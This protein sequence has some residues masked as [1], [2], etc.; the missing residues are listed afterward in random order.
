[1]PVP[2]LNRPATL[3]L[4]AMALAITLSP[5]TSLAAQIRASERAQISQTIDG[6]TLKLDYSRPR[7]RTRGVE[8]IFGAEVHWGEV[9]TPG[10]NAGTKLNVDR[11]VT[12]NGVAVPA[13]SYTVWMVVS[14]E[15]TWN[16]ALISDTT[17]FHTDHPP[18]RSDMLQFPSQVRSG[19]P[20]E[21][22]TWTIRNLT[23]VGMTAEMAWAD[24]VVSLDVKVTPSLPIDLAADKAAPFVGSYAVTWAD[25]PTPPEW[26]DT[27]ELFHA[28]GAL[29]MRWKIWFWPEM[30]EQI[31]VPLTEEWFTFGIAIDGEMFDVIREFTYE[32]TVEDGKATGFEVRLPDDMVLFRGKRN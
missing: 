14:Q 8:G 3:A 19:G 23:S 30:E 11:D 13:G 25:G 31:L 26:G 2:A 27:A 24:R 28:D 32:F 12:I 9:W 20:T 4:L 7:M 1:M 17:L 21:E 6:T 5:S 16:T 22:L 29:R 18:I 15:D 10:A